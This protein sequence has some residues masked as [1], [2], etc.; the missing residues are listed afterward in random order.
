MIVITG[1]AGFI[2]SNLVAMLNAEGRGDIVIIDRFGSDDKWKNLRQATVAKLINPDEA[3]AFLN[4]NCAK[5]EVVF[6]LGAISSTVERDV[7]LILKNNFHFSRKLFTWCIQHGKPF[8]YASS[9]ATYGDGSRGF[10]DNVKPIMLCP[11]NP[12]GF[13]KNL[14]DRHVWEGEEPFSSQVCGFK[15]FNVY[16]PNE[17]HKGSQASMFL[18][19]YNA[20]SKGNPVKLFT[21]GKQTRDFICVEDVVSAL[22]WAWKEKLPAGLYNL[23]TGTA[24]TFYDLVAA[25]ASALDVEPCIQYIAMPNELRDQYQ[26]HTQSDQSKLEG[27]GYNPR[28]V[29]IEEGAHAY[30]NLFLRNILYA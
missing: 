25:V 19:S 18:H 30:V 29:P 22:H 28:Y 4:K 20:L 3:L 24:R 27:A 16:G 1:G 13:S 6:H 2:G 11:L 5:V 21:D 7:D 8:L 23:G 17:Y 14:F 10:S 12:Y 9:A 15:F 26:D